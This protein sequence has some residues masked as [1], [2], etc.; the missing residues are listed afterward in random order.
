M[1]SLTGLLGSFT[2]QAAAEAIGFGIGVALAEALKPE[3]VALGQEAW[4]LTP[5]KAVDAGTAAAIVAEDVEQLGW[6]QGE[7]EQAGI[8]SDRFAAMLGELLNAPGLGELLRMLRRGTIGAGD[9]AHGLRKAKLETRWDS[10]VEELQD[11]R[12]D[13]AV[14]ATAIQRGLLANAGI[15]PVGPPTAVGRVEPMPVVAIDAIAEAAASGVNRERL[16]VLARIVGLPPGPGELL[17]LLNRG[18]IETADFYRGVAEGNTRNEWADVLLELRRRLLTPTEYVQARLRGWIDDGAMHAGASLS[19]ME[20]ADTDLLMKLSGRPLSFHQV[21]IGLRR[22][23]TYDGPTAGIDP[24]FLKSL[25]ESSVRPE[26]YSLAWAQRYSYPSAFVLRQLTTAG[27]L[28]AAQTEQILLYQGWEPTLAKTIA[29]RWGGSATGIGKAE[30]KTELDD[31]Y[32]GGYITEAEYRRALTALGYTGQPQD[33]LVHLGDARRVKKWREKI[34]DAIAAAHLSF[35]INDAQAS[36]ELAEIQITGEAATLLIVLWNKQRRDTI[37]N[38]TPAQIKK[39]I[40]TDNITRA[41]ALLELEHREYTP[42]DA[43]TFLDE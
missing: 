4:K 42:E 8:D 17:Q 29:G 9:F 24:A 7:A 35:K 2:E 27:D 41:D 43:A 5:M 15:L 3:A 37:A 19:G 6:G 12:L 31:E 32:E 40:G 34:V 21:F 28:T 39:S 20:T 11:E 22:G 16:E 36:A 14:I 30:T 26:W 10:A 18:A 1:A 33:L 13:P 25:E 38:L 23:G